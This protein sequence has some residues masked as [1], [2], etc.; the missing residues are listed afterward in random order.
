MSKNEEKIPGKGI[1]FCPSCAH[2]LNDPKSILN[3]YWISEDT[4]YFCWCK[5][6]SWKGD[7]I[8]TTRMVAPEL[9]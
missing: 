3:E 5:N 1:Q 6:C 9:V 7:I 2:P 8:K 4:A